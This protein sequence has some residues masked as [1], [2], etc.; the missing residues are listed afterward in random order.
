MSAYEYRHVFPFP[1]ERV[2]AFFAEPANLEK[3]TPGWLRLRLVEAPDQIRPGSLLRYRTAPFGQVWVAQ[4]SVWEPPYRFADVQLSGPY[5]Q[6][7]H[8]HT[9]AAVEGGTEIRDRI[10]YRLPGGRLGALADRLGH[11]AFLSR[12]FRYRTKRLTELL[13]ADL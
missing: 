12:L 5:R 8:T 10:R 7:E 4:I 6:W 1:L 3:L 2:S 9:F 11:R 13:A